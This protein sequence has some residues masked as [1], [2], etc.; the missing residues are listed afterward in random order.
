M[1]HAQARFP[2]RDDGFGGINGLRQTTRHGAKQQ[3]G[4]EDLHGAPWR[5]FPEA[6]NKATLF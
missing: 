4:R 3:N 5:G 1:M 6:G 2:V